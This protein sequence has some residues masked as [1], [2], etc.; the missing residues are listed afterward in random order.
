MQGPSCFGVGY[1]IGVLDFKKGVN[2]C[3]ILELA[4]SFLAKCQRLDNILIFEPAQGSLPLKGQ[5]YP[6]TEYHVLT[7]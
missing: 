4:F 3:K 6:Y 5:N 7:F 2:K 1:F